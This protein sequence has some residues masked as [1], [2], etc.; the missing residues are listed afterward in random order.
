MYLKSFIVQMLESIKHRHRL[1]TFSLWGFLIFTAIIYSCG[2]GEAELYPTPQ[3]SING[4]EV[5]PSFDDAEV[6]VVESQLIDGE[7]DASTSLSQ[8]GTQSG[9]VLSVYSD[10]CETPDPAIDSA[11]LYRGTLSMPMVAEIHMGLMSISDDP[12]S[13][14]QPALAERYSVRED[15]TLYE[16]ILRR[17]LKFSDGSPLTASDFKWS[18][19]RALKMSTGWGQANKVFANIAG[20]VEVANGTTDDLYGVEVVDDRTLII[21]LKREQPGLPAL[22]ADPVASVLKQENIEQWPAEWSNN[23]PSI[24]VP[25][26]FDKSNL[27][28]GAGPFKLSEYAI[29]FSSETCALERNEH[30]WGQ[31]AYLDGVRYVTGLVPDIG[32]STKDVTDIRNEAFISGLIDYTNLPSDAENIDDP[33]VEVQTASSTGFLVFNSALPP[34][35]DVH[36]RRSLIAASDLSAMLQTEEVTPS[37]RLLPPSL[38]TNE[39]IDPIFRYDPESALSEISMSAYAS[40]VSDFEIKFHTVFTSFLMDAYNKLFDQWEELLDLKVLHVDIADIYEFETYLDSLNSG[41]LQMRQFAVAV[42]YPDPYSVLSYFVSAFGEGNSSP[43]FLEVERMLR[44]AT[45][46]QDAARLRIQYEMIERHILEQ[47]LAMP[48]FQYETVY[49][50]KHKPW[51]RGLNMPRYLGSMFK[52][53]WIDE[54][55]TQYQQP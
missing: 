26:I 24:T 36:F 32:A 46:Q 39:L 45:E 10:F 18:W 42:N 30:Y 40:E 7:T 23:D 48:V 53:I 55:H 49:R 6:E 34:L 43:E 14:F 8:I 38:R 19:E 37:T 5:V 21:R 51:I 29:T 41:S 11:F 16:F 35:D 44:E 15:G 9:G 50:I 13:P 3:K 27:P 54:S 31:K 25:L 4:V 33:T 28:V 12:N 47:A 52:N 20:A 1:E 2:N 17:D 22:L